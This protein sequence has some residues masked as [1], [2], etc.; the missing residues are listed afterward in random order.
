[1]SQYVVAC[2]KD[3]G[4][5]LFLFV[6]YLIAVLL[7]FICIFRPSIFFTTTQKQ[8][9]T[10]MS[11]YMAV[12]TRANAQTQATLARALH[13]GRPITAVDNRH[14]GIVTIPENSTSSNLVIFNGNGGEVRF[15]PSPSPTSSSPPTRYLACR[16]CRQLFYSWQDLREH[17]I[18]NPRIC[19][20]HGMC[21]SDWQDHVES[22]MHLKC[23]RSTCPG[24][25]FSSDAEFMSHW[26]R[27]HMY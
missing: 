3:Y 6:C 19:S 4:I 27:N 7:F 18:R 25:H 20:V 14:G 1:M 11:N 17:S 23:P 5:S 26:R 13:N 16:S 2:W 9:S 21:F 10:R 22:Y 8:T 15:T 24:R 12:T